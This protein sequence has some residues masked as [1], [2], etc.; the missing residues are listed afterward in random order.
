MKNRTSNDNNSLSGQMIRA[1]RISIVSPNVKHGN[2]HAGAASVQ[3]VLMISELP[4]MSCLGPTEGGKHGDYWSVDKPISG[5]K[6]RVFRCFAEIE[7]QAKLSACDFRSTA[8]TPN[9]TKDL[10]C[11]RM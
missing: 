3:D 4:G 7:Q 10:A 6:F 5:W 11:R 8:S 9:P 1:C 2:A